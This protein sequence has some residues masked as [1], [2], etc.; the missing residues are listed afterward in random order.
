MFTGHPDGQPRDLV[1]DTGPSHAPSLVVGEPQAS[2]PTWLP[3]D[4]VFFPQIRDS[5][6]LV[7]IHPTRQH[8]EHKPKRNGLDPAPSLVDWSRSFDAD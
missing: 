5:F 2:P 6:E 4:A 3:Q 7:A 8:D 1:Q